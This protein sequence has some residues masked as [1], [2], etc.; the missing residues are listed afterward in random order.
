MQPS[1]TALTLIKEFET[2][3]SE[4]YKNPS[5][6]PTI[7]YGTIT[8]PNGK[9]VT[10]EDRP[11]TEEEATL[12]LLSHIINEIIPILTKYIKVS[13]SQN[14]IDALISLIYNIGISN[15]KESNLLKKINAILPIDLIK[16]EWMK[17]IRERDKVSGGRMRRRNKEF[18]LF[19]KKDNGN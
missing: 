16:R 15:F 11:I 9:R 8:Y 12:C 4:P 10:M 18:S 3:S 19:S 1:M 6:I 13:L 2:F 17:W 7:G 14:Q 5:G